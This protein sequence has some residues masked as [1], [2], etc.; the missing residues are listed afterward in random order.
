MKKRALVLGV[1]GQDGAYLSKLLLEKNYEVYGGSRDAQNSSFENL[2][3]FK[4]L[5]YVNLISITLTDFRSVLQ[6]IIDIKPNEI[7]NLAGQSSVALSFNQPVETMESIITGTLNILEAIRFSGEPIRFYNAGSSEC[8]GNAIN[9]V[10]EQTPF[11]PRSPYGVAK[12]TA[13]WQVANYREAYNIYACTGILFNH[14]SPLRKERFVTKKI[15]STAYK[16]STG[17]NIKLNLGN[18]NIYR[19]WGWAEEYVNAMWLMLQQNTPDD[20]V[21]ATGKTTSLKDFIKITF[22]LLGL[23]WEDHVIVD[24]GLKRP[25]DISVGLAN[26]EKAKRL[27]NWEAK[28]GIEEVIKL[29]LE[30][31]NK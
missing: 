21:I 1:S 16:I 17:L 11:R 26:P 18:I 19:D 27:L 8:F 23:N 10:D 12:A 22:N 28:I 6:T 24:E 9:A 25:T 4:I 5:D 3:E 15:I 31:E 14:E 20:F 2:K 30:H 7:Y 29:M 13:F